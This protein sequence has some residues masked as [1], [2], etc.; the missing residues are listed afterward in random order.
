MVANM[1]KASD[2][3]SRLVVIKLVGVINGKS[4]YS[5][6]C[7]CGNIVS[8]SSNNL[9]T[10]NT[11]SCGCYKSDRVREAKTRHG[12]RYSEEYSSW[13]SMKARCN[14]SNNSYYDCYGGRGISVCKEW[15]DDFAL[16]FDD[17]GSCPKGFSIDRINVD[18]G[19]FKSNCRW[20]NNTTQ[21]R[22]QR[23]RKDNKS[24]CKG[25]CFDVESKKYRVV[26]SVNKK[27]IHLGRFTDI[28]EAISVR[29]AAEV[30]YWS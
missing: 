19:Y 2:R 30:K 3:F 10:G 22:N 29:L 16:F 13:R 15:N 18:K 1:L 7:D 17:M 11:K 14:N 27:R 4:I 20:A 6:M 12:M 28:D 25:V 9:K 5:C 26:I 21:A 24:G 23:T 8:C